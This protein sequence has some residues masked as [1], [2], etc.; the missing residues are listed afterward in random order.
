[1]APPPKGGGQALR[2]GASACASSDTLAVWR[3]R[4]ERT[5][6]HKGLLQVGGPFAWRVGEKMAA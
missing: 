6:T 4:C 2:G 3:V 1:M 5:E